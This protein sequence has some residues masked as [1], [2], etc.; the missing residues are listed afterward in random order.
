MLEQKSL[1][2]YTATSSKIGII[3]TA[4]SGFR[5]WMMLYPD[6]RMSVVTQS[7]GLELIAKPIVV[8]HLMS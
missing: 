1:Y 8:M 4:T 7:I 3:N 2:T 6:K 5:S